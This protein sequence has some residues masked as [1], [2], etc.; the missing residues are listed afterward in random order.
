MREKARE[1]PLNIFNQLG[2]T[3]AVRVPQNRTKLQDRSD[4][5]FIYRQKYGFVP[6]HKNFFHKAKKTVGSGTDIGYM[7]IES[8]LVRNTNTKIFYGRDG[9]YNAV[10]NKIMR[11]IIST[12]KMHDFTFIGVKS[13][14]IIQRPH[15]QFR[16]VILKTLGCKGL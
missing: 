2:Q 12:T 14:T 4:V 11:T 7:L 1:A 8:T 5:R 13:E 6:G 9:I 10:G 15:V 16:Q 3:N